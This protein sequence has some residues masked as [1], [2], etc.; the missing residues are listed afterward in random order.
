MERLYKYY[1]TALTECTWILVLGKLPPPYE[2]SPYESSPLWKLPPP[3]SHQEFTPE[4]I[5]PYEK[6][7]PEKITSI[8]WNPL[9][10]YKSHKWKK[11]QN[12]KI[13]CLQESCATQYPYQNNQ[14]F[15][16]YTD[17]LTENTGLR[18]FLYRMK[19]SK[20]QTKVQLTKWHLLASCTSQVELKLDSQ[21]IKFG[22]YVKLL[23]S[24]LS[25]H[26]TLWI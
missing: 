19:K 17:D 4:K 6:S 15:R 26:I 3:P 21:T 12:Y 2:Y 22:K 20:N 10:T 8:A 18:Y 25:L 13:S 5:D 14:G 9:P 11:K 1:E 23:N 7:P 16:W 24:Q